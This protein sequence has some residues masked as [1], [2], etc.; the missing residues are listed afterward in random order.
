MCFLKM[1]VAASIPRFFRGFDIRERIRYTGMM[2]KHTNRPCRLPDAAH[3]M[4]SLAPDEVLRLLRS[5]NRGLKD[6]E[7][8]TRLAQLGPNVVGDGPKLPRL[9]IL[10]NQYRSP[11]ILVLLA[12]GVLTLALREWLD[13]AVIFSAV[14]A[15]TALG[16][17]QEYKAETVLES[18][19]RYVTTKAR[20]KRDGQ[21]KEIDAAELVPGDIVLVSPGDRVPADG[22]VLHANGLEIDESVLTGESLPVQK[23]ETV[24]AVATPISDRVC[25]AWSGT[26]VVQGLGTLLITATGCQTEFG[27][28]ATAVRQAERE[29]TPL[30]RSVS[31]FAS[32]A[33]L[34][35]AGLTLIVF[36]WGII[37]GYGWFEMLLIAVAIGISA[38]PE[39]LPV[40]MTVILAV[41][42]ERLGKRYGV[43]RKLLAAETLGSTSLIL[44]D[45]T[46]T[47]TQAKMQIAGILPYSGRDGQARRRL[48]TDALLT[49]DVIAQN[50]DDEPADWILAGR[51][52]E[53]SLVRDA[54]GEGVLW[55]RERTKY[56]TT[57]RLPFSSDR[58]FAAVTWKTDGTYRSSLFGAPETV[59][60][61]TDLPE[62]SRKVIEDLV[63]THAESGERVLA[64]AAKTTATEP[65]LGKTGLR[66]FAFQGLITFRD[67]LRPD[68]KRAIEHIHKSGV[69]T[70]IMTGD[71]AGTAAAVARELGLLDGG[72]KAV[73]GTELSALSREEI[74]EVLNGT[75]VFARVTPDQKLMLAEL[76]K[77]KGEIVAMTGDGVNDAPALKAAD[78]GIAVGSGTEVAKGAA[79]LVLLKDDFGTIVAAI[80]EGRRILG[81]IRRVIV[82]LLSN[83]SAELILIGGSLLAGLP[84]PLNALQILYVNLFS[85]SFPAVAFAYENRHRPRFR[86][87]SPIGKNVLD[88]EMRFLI[89][90]VGTLTSV[91]MFLLYFALLKSGLPED[92]V[93]SFIFASFGT[94]TLV[95][96]FSLRSL[97]ESILSFNPFDNLP[98]TVGVGIGLLLTAVAVYVPPIQR[99]IGV[100][101]LPLPWLLGVAL[102]C[103]ANIAAIETAKFSIRRQTMR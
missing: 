34:I 61:M 90:M 78:I 50:P 96:A 79:D 48:L 66:D 98:L 12:C 22:R 47:L 32:R 56:E 55:P 99:L 28:I 101:A 2:P 7:A 41:G 57:D 54:V 19:R 6:D 68:V 83:A 38:V 60:A 40:A 51:A 20:V 14:A 25:M 81:N 18:L 95:A 11:L 80:E 17:W 31:R 70:V 29:Q 46:G 42:V 27:R 94:Y 73:T 53:S 10:L 102:V 44:T 52:M 89:V 65:H 71:H 97:H 43:V 45:K 76:Y 1:L 36:I 91:G 8:E 93:R 4:W 49:T 26:L 23:S 63:R 13:T 3:P 59:L 33:S 62:H 75:R 77:E 21:E 24:V 39:S 100:A 58:K 16:F 64:V 87:P 86:R 15:N 37:S 103:A 88:R 85:D 82:Y 72:G 69:K 92:L 84:L 30:Q 74:R 35:L 67:P 5:A 9:R